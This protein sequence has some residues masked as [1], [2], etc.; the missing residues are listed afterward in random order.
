M[1]LIL[2][3]FLSACGSDPVNPGQA[4]TKEDLEKNGILI[5]GVNSQIA[6]F[7]GPWK[8]SLGQVGAIPGSL[9]FMP[10]VLSKPSHGFVVMKVPAM[11]ENVRFGPE[12]FTA[13]T[14]Y[15]KFCRGG[16]APVVNIKP[17]EVVYA[18]TVTAEKDGRFLS[19]KY[20]YDFESSKQ[21]VSTSF[22]ELKDSLQE[23]R[24]EFYKIDT[25]TC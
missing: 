9:F 23:R 12:V 24:F 21:F 17:G 19:L 14:Y 15:Y 18:G 16:T 7:W 20:S 10:G 22:P 8:L 5:V 4:V 13:G 1:A 3:V 2:A 25:P 11:S 6:S